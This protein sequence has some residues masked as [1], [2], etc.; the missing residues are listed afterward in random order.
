MSLNI[1]GS[2]GMGDMKGDTLDT[3]MGRTARPR[4]NDLTK[5]YPRSSLELLNGYAHLARMIDKARAR[6]AGMNG[7]YIYP[8]P[9][10]KAL[11]LFLEVSEQDFAY[12]A[13]SRT[14]DLILE[15][16]GVHGRPRSKKQVEIW[17]K[18]L[19]ERGPDDDAKWAYFNKTRDA[20]DPTRTDIVTWVDLLELEEGRHVPRR[21]GTPTP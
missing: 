9:L 11:L 7:E 16:L 10:D 21:D 6:E 1:P 2:S 18:Q 12:A 20:I 5:E 13:K 19:L 14:D 4:P 15:W 3:M 17:N 8:C